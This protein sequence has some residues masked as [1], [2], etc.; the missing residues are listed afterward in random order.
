MHK[1]AMPQAAIDRVLKRR[2]SVTGIEIDPARTAR[3]HC[4][5]LSAQLSKGE[6]GVCP[7]VL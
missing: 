4:P 7:F 3:L 2:D 6:I 5:A 1:I